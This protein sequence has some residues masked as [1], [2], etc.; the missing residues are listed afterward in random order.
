MFNRRYWLAVAI[1][2]FSF[3]KTLALV[4]N[5]PN[6]IEQRVLAILL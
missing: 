3:Q 5:L 1:L 4:V 2:A 6:T